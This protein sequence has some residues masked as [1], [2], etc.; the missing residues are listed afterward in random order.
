M[1]ELVLSNGEELVASEAFAQRIKKL[2]EFQ[3]TLQEMKNEEEE[4]KEIFRAAMEKYNVKAIE[5]GGVRITRVD[6][7]VRTSVDS[8]RLKAE[9]PAIYNEYSK[10]TTVKGSIKIQYD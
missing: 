10:T 5:V 7:T 4:V 1:N 9:Q 2:A 6:P 8:K 3:I